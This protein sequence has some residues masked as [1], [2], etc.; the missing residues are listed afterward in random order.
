MEQQFKQ[1]ISKETEQ[2]IFEFLKS[3]PNEYV[4]YQN[5]R[6]ALALTNKAF[7]ELRNSMYK[8]TEEFNTLFKKYTPDEI[9]AEEINKIAE[10]NYE[11][12]RL[13]NQC[14]F[15]PYI[16]KLIMQLLNKKYTV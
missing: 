11:L 5:W 12:Q 10:F 2:E 1:Q 6:E 3:H 15:N 9:K 14:V 7:L 13:Y 8:F 4:S 16:E